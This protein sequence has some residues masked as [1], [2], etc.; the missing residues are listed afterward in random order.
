MAVV[1]YF[2]PWKTWL[3]ERLKNELSAQGLASLEFSIYSLGLH[4]IA[5]KDI[6]LGELKLPDLVVGYTPLELWSGNLRNL[7]AS[8]V[9]FSKG[10]LAVEL[11][12]VT[13]HLAPDENGTKFQ[14]NWE[15]EKISISGTPIIFSTLAG[16]GNMELATGKVGLT[17]IIASEDSVTKA[18]FAL[19]YPA[20]DS[21]SAILT[22]HNF[23]LPWN[24]GTLSAQ[25]ISVPLYAKTPIKIAIKVK[26]IS[27]NSLLALATSNR[28]TATGLVSGTIPITIERNGKI[29]LKKGN[30]RAEKSGKIII[31]PDLIPSNASQVAILREVLAN[32]NYEIFSMEIEGMSSKQ[33]S[34]SLTIQGN[35]PDAYGGR[36][37]KLNVKLIG[38]LSD[39]DF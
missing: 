4:E 33:V 6:A 26:S 22:I 2:L 37:V 8:S 13:A 18:D 19:S 31:S 38:D 23:T 12:N 27:L 11:K 16:K 25:N 32:F 28:A 35:N 39:W 15:I 36:A 21:N 3:E 20:Y 24:E 7:R 29:T 14:G 17:G 30:L 9:T 1:A 34:M 5:I 10:K